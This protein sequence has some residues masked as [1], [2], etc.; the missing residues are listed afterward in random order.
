VKHNLKVD[1][2]GATAKAVAYAV[3]H[4]ITVLG[5][6]AL[7]ATSMFPSAKRSDVKL[8]A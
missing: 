2:N 1:P 8:A 4:A 3:N 6:D 7:L 5:F